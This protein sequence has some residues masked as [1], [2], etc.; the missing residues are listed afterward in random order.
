MEPVKWTG[1]VWRFSRSAVRLI[2]YTCFPWPMQGH[3]AFSQEAHFEA[4]R[5]SVQRGLEPLPRTHPAAH[6]PA[7]AHPGPL[8]SP[9]SSWREIRFRAKGRAVKPNITV[10]P[11]PPL[12]LP[13][14]ERYGPL[15]RLE[16]LRLAR[17][18]AGRMEEHRFRSPLLWCACPEQVH[19]LDR[20]DYD[21]LIYD[22]DR[23]WDDLPPAWEGSLASAADVVFAA[24]PELA[25]RLSPCSGNIAL[26]PNGVTYPLFSRIAAPSRPRP[27]DPV[28]GWAGTIHGDLDLSPLLYAAQARPR[29]TF[30]LLG[31]REQNP[32][33]HRLARL[34]N[35]HFLPPCP[36]ME[37]PE[38]LS[39]CRVLLNFL[40]EDQPDCDVIP[41]R[42]YEYL[43]TGRPIVSMLWPDQVEHFPDVVYGAH[44]HQEFLTLCE[45]A[46]EEPPAWVSQRRLS[47]GAAAAWSLR[48]GQVSR[49]LGT[50]GLL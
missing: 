25:E 38:H 3:A 21:G 30:L 22:C 20:L 24:S 39:R 16:Q 29:W 23:E 13:A 36:L 47:H 12:L 45:H 1:E 27:E 33:L 6:H 14:D 35:V 15:F 40:R 5:L 2:Y 32:L 8:F 46:L 50:A 43:S 28:L 10:Y 7:E 41:T 42:I 17:F 37:V 31:R 44:S 34:P 11:L 49:I 26:L 19:L 4:D 18:I 48:A 9:S